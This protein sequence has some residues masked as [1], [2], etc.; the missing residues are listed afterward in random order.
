MRYKY[1]ARDYVQGWFW[2][3][4]IS[5]LPLQVLELMPNETKI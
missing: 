3:D 1:I 2:F 4:L 5:S